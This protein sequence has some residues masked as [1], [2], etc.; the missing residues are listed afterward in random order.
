MTEYYKRRERAAQAIDSA[1]LLPAKERRDWRNSVERLTLI[2]ENTEA[3]FDALLNQIDIYVESP[4]RPQFFR[5]NP[6]AGTYLLQKDQIESII[7]AILA[8]KETYSRF[9]GEL[10][11]P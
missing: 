4:K 2:L 5:G 3:E 6:V 9:Q 1:N 7:S 10:N 11:T 8:L